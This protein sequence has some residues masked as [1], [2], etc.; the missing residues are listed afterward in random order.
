MNLYYIIVLIILVLLIFPNILSAIY[1][2]I[3]PKNKK[4][5]K[6]VGKNKKI[7]LSCYTAEWCPHCVDFNRDILPSIKKEFSNH[8]YISIRS[9]DCTNDK[10]G[11]IKTESGNSITGFPTLITNIYIDGNMK[12]LQYDGSRNVS[13]IINYL[14]NL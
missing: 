11:N 13:E 7:I 10:D 3:T 14:K 6:F 5:E 9:V 8:P 1:T 4:L 12:E 2:Y